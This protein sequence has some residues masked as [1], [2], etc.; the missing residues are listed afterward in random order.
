MFSKR[1]PFLLPFQDLC[2]IYLFLLP[3][4][5]LCKRIIFE[6]YIFHQISRREMSFSPI[7]ICIVQRSDSSRRKGAVNFVNKWTTHPKVAPLLPDATQARSSSQIP[8]AHDTHSRTHDWFRSS[9]TLHSRFTRF[10]V[11]GTEEQ[12]RELSRSAHGVS[13]VNVVNVRGNE[14]EIVAQPTSGFAT[15]AVLRDRNCNISGRIL[16][17]VPSLIAT[18]ANERCMKYVPKMAPSDRQRN[19]NGVFRCAINGY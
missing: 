19:S 5:D 15:V 2:R 11:F 4:Q 8:S 17:R 18:K 7:V 9:D 16:G 13:R 6:K 1:N 10:I 12:R 3:F 14:T